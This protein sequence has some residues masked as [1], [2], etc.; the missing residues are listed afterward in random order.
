MDNYSSSTRA[1][2]AMWLVNLQYSNWGQPPVRNT[3]LQRS[4]G[5]FMKFGHCAVSGKVDEKATQLHA[6]ASLKV[7]L[8]TTKQ[9]LKEGNLQVSL[10]NIND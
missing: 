1:I 8:D 9:D 3:V 10:D 2:F 6:I 4:I 5:S 7:L